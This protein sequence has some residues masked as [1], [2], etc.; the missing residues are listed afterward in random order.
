[1]VVAGRPP[2][3][4]ADVTSK[5]RL[6]PDDVAARLVELPSRLRECEGLAAVWLFGSFARGEATPVSDVDLAYLASG[7]P[8]E[9]RAR[10]YDVVVE[11]LGTDEVTLADVQRLPVPVAWR[12]LAEGKLLILRDAKSVA[13]WVE[14][15]LRVAP[16]LFVL[17]RWGNADFLRGVVMGQSE[18]DRERILDLLRGIARDL[19]DLREKARMDLQ[20]YITSRD[21]QA[22]VERRL[23]T[24]VEG[25]VNVGNHIIARRRLGAPRDYADVFRILGGAG[26]LSRSVAEGMADMARLRNLIVHLYWT[27]DHTRIHE[28]LPRRIATLESFVEEVGRWLDRQTGRGAGG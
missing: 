20:V 19:E 28:S 5:L 3:R 17:R 10:L 13:E 22:V 14:G 2:D 26:I 11:A 21:A 7:D 6:L 18:V 9:V 27:I 8:E 1:V 25:C 23:Q 24:A 12:V 4:R 16:D 15:L